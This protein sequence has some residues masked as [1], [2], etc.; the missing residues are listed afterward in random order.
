MSEKRERTIFLS[1]LIA[2]RSM[3]VLKRRLIP[4]SKSDGRSATWSAV[5]NS[6]DI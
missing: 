4:V 2:S 3:Q 5:Y 1:D 6:K